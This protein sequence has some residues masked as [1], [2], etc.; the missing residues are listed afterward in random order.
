M[1]LTCYSF[2]EIEDRNQL[3]KKE[4]KQN[5][6]SVRRAIHTKIFEDAKV[7]VVWQ[8]KA[9]QQVIKSMEYIEQEDLLVTTSFDKKVK[10]WNAKTGDYLDSLQQNYNKIESAPIAYYNTKTSTLYTSDLKNSK[11]IAPIDPI[12]V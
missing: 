9:H 1:Y 12:K 3:S 4:S 6:E 11:Q 7:S 2:H 10:I 8:I 5:V